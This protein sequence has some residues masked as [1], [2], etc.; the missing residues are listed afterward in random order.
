M[1]QDDCIRIY[2][3]I[4]KEIKSN[5]EKFIKKIRKLSDP[6]DQNVIFMDDF[7]SLLHK[8]QIDITNE[9]RERLVQV[10]PAGEENGRLRFNIAKLYDQKYN[11]KLRKLY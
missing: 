4:F 11:M 9:D 5:W 3:K 1:E 2:E 7:M 10:F 6:D 8:Y